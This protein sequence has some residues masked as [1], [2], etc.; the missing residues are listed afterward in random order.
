MTRAAE[1]GAKK[2]SLEIL[3]SMQIARPVKLPT[4]NGWVVPGMNSTVHHSK[5]RN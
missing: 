1:E 4:I 2:N 5:Y 3:F